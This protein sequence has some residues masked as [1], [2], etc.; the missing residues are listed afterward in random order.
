MMQ[1]TGA[2]GAGRGALSGGADPAGGVSTRR[3]PL[4]QRFMRAVVN[5]GVGVILRSPVRGILS[6]SL[7]LLTVRGRKTGTDYTLP[8]QYARQGRLIYV[9][10][11]DPGRKHWWRNLIGGAPV[12]VLIEGASLS[13][14]AE[15]LSSP[16]QQ[17]EVLEGLTAYF[18]RFHAAASRYK[19]RWAPDGS[20]DPTDLRRAAAAAVMVRIRLSRT[21]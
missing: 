21:A 12:R 6:R 20:F 13:G 7:L 3:R 17:P 8:V 18:T 14:D 10:P 9:M 5:P 15:V 2:G 4:G 1:M 11:G 19:V 16:G